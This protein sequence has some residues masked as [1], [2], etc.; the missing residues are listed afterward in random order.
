MGISS[1]PTLLVTG[2]AGQLG[3]RVVELLL[4]ASVGTVI[5]AT[6]HPYKLTELVARG[7]V[8][9]KADFSEPDTLD[10]AF[11]GVDRLLIISTDAVDAPGKRLAQH[12]AAIAAAVRAGVKHVVY[13]S[14][15]A[16]GP[17]S[18]ITIA[19]DHHSTE[20]ALAASGLDYTVLRNNVYADLLLQSLPRAV[21][22]GQLVAAAA[23]GGVGY[24]TREDCARAAVAAL[25]SGA[26]RKTVDITGPAVVTQ[27]ELARLASELSGRPVS[28]VPIS[29][30]ELR[31]GL[32]AAG[33][34]T[35]LAEVLVSFDVAIAQG[36]LTVT[37][38]GVAELTG[39]E[40]QSVS[41][42]LTAHKSQLLQA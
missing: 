17:E 3:R 28:Y 35:G 20:E 11:A 38:P 22:T 9:R 5:A 4:D 32:G 13:T 16:P 24:V 40:P 14:L 29:A 36:K 27:E 8:V 18:P 25:I 10:D 34:P 1:S 31:V 41:D 7:A 2:A 6:R 26:G 21:A 12:R 33:L 23:Q 15:T 19:P 30:D 42:F 39:R 37:S